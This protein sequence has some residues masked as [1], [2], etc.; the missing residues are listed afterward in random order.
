MSYPRES[1]QKDTKDLL[2]FR[3]A[4]YA[5]ALATPLNRALAQALAISVLL[6][7]LWLLLRGRKI[8][9]MPRWESISLASFIALFAISS[10]IGGLTDA[11]PQ[12]GKIWVLLCFFPIV[13]FSD[14][15]SQKAV[16]EI[17][18]WATVLSSAIGIGR[19]FIN[20]L[21][22]AVALSGGYTTL[23]LLE[24]AMLPLALAFYG[25][26]KGKQRYPYIA[27]IMIMGLGLFLT[28]TRTGWLAALIGLVIVGY[29]FSKKVTLATVIAIV[30]I[31]AILPQSRA[32]IQKR[33]E[34]DKPGGLTSGR[35]ILWTYS[36]TPLSNLP[37]LGYGPGSFSRL[38]PR[39]VLAQTGDMGIKSWHSTPLETLL[40]SGPPALLALLAFALLFLIRS[41]KR[42]FRAE[43]RMPFDLGM[44]AALI[45]IYIGGLSTNLFRDLMLTSLLALLWSMVSGAEKTTL[46]KAEASE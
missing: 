20:D 34:S 14:R 6:L 25:Q 37:I 3:W 39:E 30:A 2:I 36:I 15:L 19:F 27:A 1:S 21:D 41:W 8:H 4:V 5:L 40:E 23:A 18:L 31:V 24:A 33:L 28:E 26:L 22:R 43:R 13:A 29:N 32:V 9:Y 10:L 17:L 12:L 46:E 11:R 16:G 7:G 44:F 45:A 38:V 35:A 42:Y